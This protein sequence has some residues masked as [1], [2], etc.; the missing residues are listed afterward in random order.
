METNEKYKIIED[1][2][3]HYCGYLATDLDYQIEISKDDFSQPLY[4]QAIKI[5]LLNKKIDRKIAFMYQPFNGGEYTIFHIK[6]IKDHDSIFIH[7][8]LRL[9]NEGITFPW[10]DFRGMGDAPGNTFEE[11]VNNYFSFVSKLLNEN[12]KEVVEGTHWIDL[13]TD[14]ESMGR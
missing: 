14:W 2:F 11:K 12:L 9:N 6:N 3:L 5:N 1:S 10:K 4:H 13:P 8:Y 7:S